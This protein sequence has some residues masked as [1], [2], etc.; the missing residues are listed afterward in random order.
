MALDYEMASINTRCVP[1]P[2]TLEPPRI[3]TSQFVALSLSGF[4][5]T[6]DDH[7]L[8]SGQTSPGI[9]V[10]THLRIGIGIASQYDSIY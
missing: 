8:T 7:T 3:A 5:S 10:H 4:T 9:E 1:K 2:S 6:L